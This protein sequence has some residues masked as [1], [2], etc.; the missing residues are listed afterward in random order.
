MTI[1]SD[2]TA[3]IC[4]WCPDKEACDVWA[5]QNGHDLSHGICPTCKNEQYALVPKSDEII[6]ANIRLP[7]CMKTAKVSNQLN[8]AL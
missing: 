5:E 3:M 2:N 4:A 1:R 7:E 8:L 6:A